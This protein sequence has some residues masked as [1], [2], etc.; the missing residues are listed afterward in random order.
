MK[1]KEFITQL[2]EVKWKIQMLRFE[3]KDKSVDDTF[4]KLREALES[5][6]V[7]LLEDGTLRIHYDNSIMGVGGNYKPE[8]QSVVLPLMILYTKFS[9]SML[10]AGEYIPDDIYSKA[11]AQKE[12][13]GEAIR[14]I[15]IQDFEECV[16]T[17]SKVKQFK[18][19]LK[20]VRPQ[21]YHIAGSINEY[22]ERVVTEDAEKLKDI[23]EIYEDFK[24]GYRYIYF[25]DEIAKEKVKIPIE[26]PEAAY[27]VM[28]MYA[29][30]YNVTMPWLKE[31]CPTGEW[32]PLVPWNVLNKFRM[33]LEDLF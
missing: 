14:E 12:I 2:E 9:Y 6:K 20:W 25:Y 13:L 23:R 5:F 22:S 4:Y 18:R 26:S 1:Q 16:I 7:E 30:A 29:R 19:F 11:C 17:S 3:C 8:N 28:I 33:L 27:A 10:R 32:C 21:L 31:Y 24:I 15:C